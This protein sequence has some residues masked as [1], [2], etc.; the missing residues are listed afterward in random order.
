MRNISFA[1]TTPQFLDGS[2]TVTRRL[3][4]SFLNPGDRLMACEKCMGL[5]FG[6][7]IVRLGEIEV[8]T[9][10][11]E[12]LFD[13]TKDDCA[14]E[15]FPEFEPQDFVKMFCDHMGCNPDK[16]VTRI[17]FRRVSPKSQEG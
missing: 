10:R 15:G 7:K 9:V 14:R 1:L 11:R 6:G 3:G 13:I 2:K 4:W 8:V 17:E 16:E 5:G 12:L